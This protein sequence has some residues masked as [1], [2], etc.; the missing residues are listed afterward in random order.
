MT[1]MFPYKVIAKKQ[2][3]LS[4]G[5]IG[6]QHHVI[7]PVA[8]KEEYNPQTQ[9]CLAIE[10]ILSHSERLLQKLNHDL[11]ETSIKSCSLLGG[12]IARFPSLARLFEQLNL[13][14][15]FFQEFS[16]TVVD[17]H[18]ELMEKLH[19]CL[20]SKGYKPV[21]D[22]EYQS[23]A[24]EGPGALQ[25]LSQ[26]QESF[27]SKINSKDDETYTEE[28]M[29]ATTIARMNW[30][31]LNCLDEPE[32]EGS[33]EDDLEEFGINMSIW[34]EQ[35][36]KKLT[37][38]T[39]QNGAAGEGFSWNNFEISDLAYFNCTMVRL[40]TRVDE[41]EA[42]PDK[43]EEEDTSTKSPDDISPQ[44]E[45]ENN[46]ASASVAPPQQLSTRS[47]R[48]KQAKQGRRGAAGPLTDAQAVSTSH[49]TENP[50]IAASPSRNLVENSEGLKVG[51]LRTEEPD[52]YLK[53]TNNEASVDKTTQADNLVSRPQPAP[54]PRAG[55]ETTAETKRSKKTKKSKNKPVGDG[56]GD[57][58][59]KQSSPGGSGPADAMLSQGAR[60]LVQPN[61][62]KN[63]ASGGSGPTKELQSEDSDDQE[64]G[65]AGS[66]EQ[67]KIKKEFKDL[68]ALQI[69]RIETTIDLD[70][71]EKQSLGEITD[72]IGVSK[73]MKQKAKK[74]LRIHIEKCKKEFEIQS[75]KTVVE[76][77]TETSDDLH[78]DP[79]AVRRLVE[80]AARDSDNSES[81]QKFLNSHLF[82]S[83]IHDP[84]L[85]PSVRCERVQSHTIFKSWSQEERTPNEV[86]RETSGIYY[87]NSEG[88]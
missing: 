40:P 2:S 42:E 20:Q 26:D 52:Q 61:A 13:H 58:E 84:R 44:I 57:G 86:E 38:S 65:A 33:V 41:P 14:S 53:H 43:Q 37:K 78:F 31:F 80:M 6:E 36:H 9:L 73:K 85:S 49:T 81:L 8:I 67:E 19:W 87:G 32:E 72:F 77:L 83:H 10:I 21:A 28:E 39:I 68:L 56:G 22:Q 7:I 69:S 64:E 5:A 24:P 59:K 16:I 71:Y 75:N 70:Q 1:A 23:A 11:D 27:L 54:D 62:P 46:P 18:Q 48:K 29:D 47:Q 74:N 50:L 12:K 17:E 51:H 30:E 15:R 34:N 76:Y 4:I 66:K 63:A 60:G 45:I 35:D 82:G 25:S 79:E 55:S 3:R 88:D